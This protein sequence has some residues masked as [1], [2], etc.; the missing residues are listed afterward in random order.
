MS[1]GLSNGIAFSKFVAPYIKFS[2]VLYIKHI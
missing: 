1:I 2:Y